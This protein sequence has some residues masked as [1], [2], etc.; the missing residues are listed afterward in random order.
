M[1]QNYQSR[2]PFYLCSELCSPSGAVAAVV[3]VADAELP[4]VLFEDTSDSHI[5][6]SLVE[7]GIL[8]ELVGLDIHDWVEAAH[9]V[10]IG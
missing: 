3:A 8:S 6:Y 7:E 4:W 5:D 9:I 10:R 1:K 2:P